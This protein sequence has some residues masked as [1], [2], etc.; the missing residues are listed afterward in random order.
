[1]LQILTLMGILGR[2]W[3]SFSA[4]ASSAPTVMAWKPS[5][6]LDILL[7]FLRGKTKGRDQSPRPSPSNRQF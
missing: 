6:P 2:S 5:P 7:W 1:M 4:S 3:H